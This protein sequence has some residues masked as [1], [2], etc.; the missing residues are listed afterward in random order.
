MQPIDLSIALS[1]AD[2]DVDLLRDVIDAFLG[3]CPTL[4]IDLGRAIFSDD[5]VTVQRVSH[6]IKGSLRIFGESPA[7][8]IARE[9]EE[10]GRT[11]QLK[12]ATVAFERLK[13]SLTMLCEQLLIGLQSL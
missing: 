9:L 7:R 4:I 5:A 13:S 11:Q 2:G 10:M 1:S 8:N 6:T 12:E 3:E